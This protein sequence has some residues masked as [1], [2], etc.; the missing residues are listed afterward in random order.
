MKETQKTQ[1]LSSGF[2]ISRLVAMKIQRLN[3]IKIV[4]REIKN[5]HNL[6]ECRIIALEGI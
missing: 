3:F 6:S 4:S 2:R 5:F 1:N